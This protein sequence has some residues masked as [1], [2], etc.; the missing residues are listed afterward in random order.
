MLYACII[1]IKAHH[2]IF[3]IGQN[4]LSSE[5]HYLSSKTF[6]LNHQPKMVSSTTLLNMS[7]YRPLTK[8]VWLCY[9]FTCIYGLKK[10][11]YFRTHAC[12]H[13]THCPSCQLK[14][15]YT[16]STP[17]EH[18]PPTHK[19]IASSRIHTPYIPPIEILRMRSRMEVFY[20]WL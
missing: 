14:N 4:A 11:S 10:H 18:I 2:L 20:C 12:Y 1:L 5:N 3:Y 13:T 8:K 6:S 15:T 16:L 19:T 9:C 7:I 17:V